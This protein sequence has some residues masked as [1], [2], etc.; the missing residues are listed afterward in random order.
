MA[1]RYQDRP[2]PADDDYDRGSD[3]HAPARGESDP[4]AELARLIGQTDPF[5]SMGRAN[6]RVQPRGSSNEQYQPPPALPT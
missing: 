2:L 4:L 5:A 3:P 1:D 6:A